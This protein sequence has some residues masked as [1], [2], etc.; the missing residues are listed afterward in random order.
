[1]ES[2]FPLSKNN[3]DEK[4]NSQINKAFPAYMWPIINVGN[5]DMITDKCET[6]DQWKDTVRSMKGLKNPNYPN[7]G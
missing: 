6:H 7:H 3:V 2:K 4:W 1:M 5:N